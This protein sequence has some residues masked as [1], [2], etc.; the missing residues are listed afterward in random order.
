MQDILS[1]ESNLIEGKL[2]NKSDPWRIDEQG[3]LLPK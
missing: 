3:Q 2:T 1:D